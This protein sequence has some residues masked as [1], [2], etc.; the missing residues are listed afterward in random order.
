MDAVWHQHILDTRDYH[1]DSQAVFGEY[2]HHY[3][4]FG[5]NG[6][7]DAQNLLNA[8]AETKAL[9]ARTFGEPM[10]RTGTHN[11]DLVGKC[12]T[13]RGQCNHCNRP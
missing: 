10:D 6:P 4:Y 12:H 7:Q 3:P 2:F 1:V 8:F 5:M 13:C 9:Y 11:T